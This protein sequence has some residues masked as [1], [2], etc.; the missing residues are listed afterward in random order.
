M[1]FAQPAYTEQNGL[2][3]NL[4]GRIQE[5][6]KA[7]YPINEA[8]EDWKIFNLISNSLYQT[9]LFSDFLSIRELA[10]KEISNFSELDLLPTVHK[11]TNHKSLSEDTN[12]KV[13]IKLLDYYYSNAIARASK[14]MSDC[15]NININNKKNGTNN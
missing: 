2:F 3:A 7:S 8:M 11:I 10:L 12:E 4:E 6:R 1:L 13:K 5:C 9:N 14:T 15:R